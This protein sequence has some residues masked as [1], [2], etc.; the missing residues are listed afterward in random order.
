MAFV[1][2]LILDGGFDDFAHVAAPTAAG[3]FSAFGVAFFADALLSS[4]KLPFTYW[5][6]GLTAAIAALMLQAVPRHALAQG[7]DAAFDSEGGP[8]RA[9]A[10]LFVAYALVLTS[11]AHGVS[12]AARAPPELGHAPSTPTCSST[13]HPHTSSFPSPNLQH[14]ISAHRAIRAGYKLQRTV[15]TRG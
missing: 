12:L 15:H 13:K 2:R 5:L 8:A 3:A 4:P 14:G 9:R 1:R 10:W 6:P 7:L 11:A